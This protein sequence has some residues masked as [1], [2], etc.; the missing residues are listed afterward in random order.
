MCYVH[1]QWYDISC[2]T[3][4]FVSLTIATC[5]PVEIAAHRESTGCSFYCTTSQHSTCRGQSMLQKACSLRKVRVCFSCAVQINLFHR[6]VELLHTSGSLCHTVGM[7]RDATVSDVVFKSHL[8][9]PV[10]LPCVILSN[11]S[12][13][14]VFPSYRLRSSWS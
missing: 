9:Q 5:T 7:R 4:Y 11:Y 13:P 2:A 6:N 12:H 10:A 3:L 14:T 1:N 8:Q